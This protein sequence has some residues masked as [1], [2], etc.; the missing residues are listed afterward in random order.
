MLARAF[1][2]LGWLAL[3]ACSRPA[4]RETRSYEVRGFVRG[5]APDRSTVEIQ[6]E[7]IPGLMPS[8]TMPFAVRARKEIASLNIGDAIAFRLMVAGD[9]WSLTHVRKIDRAALHL[10]AS[11]TSTGAAPSSS[12]RLREGDALP[13]FHLLDQNGAPV[14]LASFRGQPLILTFIFTRCPMPKFC[15][16]ISAQFAQLQSAIK[17]G[18]G[19]LASTRLLSITLDPAFD[20]PPVLKQY[21]EQLQAD[22]KVWTFA[23]G[24][25]AQVDK[26]TREFAVYV[27]PEGGTISHGLATALIAPDGRVAQMWRGNTWKPDEVLSAVSLLER[28][29]A[30]AEFKNGNG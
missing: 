19:A 11:P 2:V 15:P 20:Q 9:D 10:P 8:M 1:L 3:A 26:L 6:H 22:P 25:Q 17:S 5:F 7:D 27:Q 28:K 21:A 13:D 4:N 18:A 29:G 12:S 14:S 16:L 24:E 30:R 23:T